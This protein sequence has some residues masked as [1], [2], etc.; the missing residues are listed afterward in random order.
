MKK[1]VFWIIII[2]VL[3]GVA[4][5]IFL[6]KSN[7]AKKDQITDVVNNEA[8]EV[9]ESDILK[10]GDISPLFTV[11]MFD[12]SEIAIA[13]LKGKVVLIQFWATWCPPCRQEL[14]VVEKEIID[15]FKGKEFVYLPISREDSY[16]DIKKFREEFGYTFPMGMDTDRSIYYQFATQTIP[17]NYIL[18]KEGKIVF[19]EK[20]YSEE[21]LEEI[22]HK[23]EKEL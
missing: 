17:R 5:F 14:A 18:N 21:M 9:D 16:D 8:T 20:G 11:K 4:L 19:M 12:G 7:S 10:V 23:I 22:I 15:R 13:D 1:P 2:I 6:P 3:A